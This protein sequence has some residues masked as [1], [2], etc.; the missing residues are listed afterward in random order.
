MNIRVSALLAFALAAAAAP[1]C[2][3]RVNDKGVSLDINEGGRAEDEWVRSYTLSKGGTFEIDTAFGEIEIVAATGNTVDV[4]A[5]REVRGRSDEAAS[6]LLKQLE[7]EEEV[8]SDRVRVRTPRPD[9][10]GPFRQG[11]RLD[12]QI[13][14]PAGLNVAVKIENG[15]VRLTG[16][17]G[18][19]NIGLTNG[20]VFGR[21][22]SGGLEAQTVNGVVI[23]QM[24]S[25]TDDIRITTVNG[26]AILGLPPKL[27]ATIEANAINGGVVVMDT[28]PLVSTTKERQHLSGRLGNGTGPRIELRTTNG[29]VRLG[30]GEPP[31]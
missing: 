3:V 7:I 15:S 2:D 9:R 27:N 14:L 28:L 6:K 4:K 21:S 30:G 5:R 26:H 12:Y 23:M 24:A 16:V 22:V 11:I 10:S 31:T 29:N 20:R 18:R 1:A 13:S 8:T 19:F 17:Q 25:V